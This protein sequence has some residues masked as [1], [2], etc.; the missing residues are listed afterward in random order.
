MACQG[1]IIGQVISLCHFGCGASLLRALLNL[2]VLIYTH[3]DF[4]KMQGEFFE[5][6]LSQL[7]GAGVAHGD[8][9]GASQTSGGHFKM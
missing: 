6:I 4:T 5:A 7:G 2:V 9:K 1:T 3:G 8:K